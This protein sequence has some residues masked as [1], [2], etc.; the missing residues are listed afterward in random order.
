MFSLHDI[1]SALHATGGD[2]TAAFHELM[3]SAP[4][5]KRARIREYE[6]LVVP[7]GQLYIG[8]T[9]SSLVWLVENMRVPSIAY[10]D[11][12]FP[13]SLRVML[14]DRG[15]AYVMLNA[16]A[17]FG[18]TSRGVTPRIR[19]LYRYPGIDDED[20]GDYV[21]QDGFKVLIKVEKKRT[22]DGEFWLNIVWTRTLDRF[23]TAD[24]LD[25]PLQANPFPFAKIETHGEDIDILLGALR[26]LNVTVDDTPVP[27]PQSSE[28]EAVD[29]DDSPLPRRKQ[30]VSDDDDPIESFAD[31]PVE[32]DDSIDSSSTDGESP[33][34]PSPI[35]ISSDDDDDGGDAAQVHVPVPSDADYQEA[36]DMI[37][38]TLSDALPAG[39]GPENAIKY[40]QDHILNPLTANYRQFAQYLFS[41][42]MMRVLDQTFTTP[43]D[44]RILHGVDRGFQEIDWRPYASTV[45]KTEMLMVLYMLTF[46][47]ERDPDRIGAM[48]VRHFRKPLLDFLEFEG[49]T[50]PPHRVIE[51]SA[52]LSVMS[53]TPREQ[54][55][56]KNQARSPLRQRQRWVRA[57]VTAALEFL[58]LFG[59][60]IKT[61]HLLPKWPVFYE[62][63]LKQLVIGTFGDEMLDAFAIFI[64]KHA[65]SETARRIVFSVM[66]LL[67]Q[68]GDYEEFDGGAQTMYSLF[69]LTCGDSLFGTR[70]KVEQG[71][72]DAVDQF[73]KHSLE[74]AQLPAD[75]PAEKDGED[76]DYDDET[77]AV[78]PE[79]DFGDVTDATQVIPP[80]SDSGYKNP[81]KRTRSKKNTVDPFF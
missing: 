68:A 18:G 35:V 81:L 15:E 28:E 51:M 59:G 25:V 60:A 27:Q 24:I 65:G 40:V 8:Y 42:F 71:L 63:L 49:D 10:T 14:L 61:K 20:M 1:R 13:M 47:N 11:N 31:E 66:V 41:N 9:P 12:M 23:V 53:L 76:S 7:Q 74:F 16:I 75:F 39:V 80:P 48:Y 4:P 50:E 30:F 56:I 33:R 70:V 67:T 54:I 21:Q 34:P 5:K 73:R 38:N 37:E 45:A 26:E 22:E 62:Y 17:P 77:Q 58:C 72:I 57:D 29:S 64:D 2:S 3:A 78:V 44:M 46:T 69:M 55:M 36:T 32:T 43:K 19:A 6:P 79:P 52:D